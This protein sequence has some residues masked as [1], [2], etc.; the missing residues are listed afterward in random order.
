MK[1]FGLKL[2]ASNVTDYKWGTLSKSIVNPSGNWEQY[3]PSY[4]PQVLPDGRDPQSCWIWGSL[5]KLETYL[6]LLYPNDTWNLSERFVYNGLEASPNGGDPFECGEFVRRN[7]DVD[8]EVLPIGNTYD[9]FATPRPLT[10]ELKNKAKALLSLVTIKQEYVWNDFDH[11]IT[12]LEKQRRI[13]EALKLDCVGVSLYAWEMDSNGL[14]YRPNNAPDTHWC[15][16][17]KESDEAYFVFD[18]YD[19]AIK[20][21][22][23]DMDFSI[24]IRYLVTKNIGVDKNSLL[25]QS[26]WCRIIAWL[27]KFY[28]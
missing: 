14:Y 20:K 21:V 24:C 11:A 13:T 22:R 12:L 9:E 2:G 25:K 10:E 16:I 23:K 4:E 6:K 28:E 17:F 7:G 1:N 26:L 18:T 27:K 5:N 3:L 19:H 15:F 8:E